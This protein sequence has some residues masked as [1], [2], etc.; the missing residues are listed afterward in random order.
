MFVDNK[1]SEVAPG[2]GKWHPQKAGKTWSNSKLTGMQVSLPTTS[3][4]WSEQH[5]H[6][7]H[8]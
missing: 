3:G 5:S 7:T 1:A 6:T 4:G 2:G 8:V